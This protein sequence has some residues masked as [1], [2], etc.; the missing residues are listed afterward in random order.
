[1]AK[2]RDFPE[3]RRGPPA[4]LWL[5]VLMAACAGGGAEQPNL[6][7][8]TSPGERDAAAADADATPLPDHARLDASMPVRGHAAVSASLASERDR[9]LETVA[10]DRCATWAAFDDDQRAVLLL[11]TD[12]LGQRTLLADAT[13]A[14]AHV[15]ALHAVR[16][17]QHEGCVRCCGDGEFNRAYFSADDALIAAFRDDALA[18][19][20]DSHDL[21]GPHQPFTASRETHLGLP[22]GQAHFFSLDDDLVPLE[23]RGVE[24]VIDA[25]AIEIDLD[26]NL[27]HESAPRCDYGDE[28]GLE[29]YQQLW[30]EQAAG[31]DVELE[32]VPEGC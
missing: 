28:S 31:G 4:A 9:L 2:H 12:L 30:R 11:L 6:D 22:R 14:L 32:Y 13:S 25:R 15:T 29:R 21:A 23:R 7:G 17:R 10:G 5:T 8:S 16:G 26:F 27:L 20:R 1:M 24:G 18:A 3:A 19:W